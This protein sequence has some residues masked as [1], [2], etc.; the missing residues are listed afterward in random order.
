MLMP[1]HCVIVLVAVGCL[2]L[3]PGTAQKAPPAPAAAPLVGTWVLNLAKSTFTPGPP[4][5]SDT[6]TYAAAGEGLS[7]SF[8]RVNA[9]GQTVHFEWTAN[10]DGKDYPCYGLPTVDTVSITRIDRF[11]S[12]ITLKKAGKVVERP[13]LVVS[14]DGKVL[15]MTNEG[16]N[17]QGVA[18]RNIL[19]FDRRE[20]RQ[21]P[22]R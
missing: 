18:F 16:T 21:G 14:Q 3:V 2:A 12:E 22:E 1:G 8:E 5:K 11:T 4:P 9:N 6:R 13:R 10:D 20:S 17:A 19:V 15:T 7:F